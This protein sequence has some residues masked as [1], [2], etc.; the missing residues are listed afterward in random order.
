MA[1]VS[2]VCRYVRSKNA[3]PFWIT[4]DLFFADRAAFERYASAPA[5]GPEAFARLYGVAPEEVGR[6][7]VE[8]LSV[9]KVS[10]PRP[11]PQGGPRERDIHGGQFFAR[12]LAVE[13]G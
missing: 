13:L 8:S 6:F 7:P 12:L 2:E 1:K 9:L 10:F 5:L 11:T 4:V 3:G